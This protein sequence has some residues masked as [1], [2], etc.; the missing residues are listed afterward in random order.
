MISDD[1]KEMLERA[2]GDEFEFRHGPR[3]TLESVFNDIGHVRRCAF[4]SSD[5][6]V[7]AGW[8]CLA[9]W[10]VV[11]FITSGGLKHIPYDGPGGVL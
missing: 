3:I 7:Y 6:A 10:E 4:S 11:N 5:P 8:N 2:I 1:V 9:L